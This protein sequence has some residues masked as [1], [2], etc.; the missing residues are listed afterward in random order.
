MVR[1]EGAG[2]SP[3]PIYQPNLKFLSSGPSG[4][5]PEYTI[6]PR[7]FH[8]SLSTKRTQQDEAP[9]PKYAKPQSLGVQ[10]ESLYKS[11][12]IV[13]FGTAERV[14]LAANPGSTGDVG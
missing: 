13:K 7:T 11:A 12:Q 14:T 2:S 6:P 4:R 10:V 3:G 9:G 8:V 5:G 1:H